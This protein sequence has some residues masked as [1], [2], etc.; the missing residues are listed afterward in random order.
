MSTEYTGVTGAL[1]PN[2]IAERKPV[3]LKRFFGFH[4]RRPYFSNGQEITIWPR[5]NLRL[6]ALGGTFHPG[7]V[8]SVFAR[9]RWFIREVCR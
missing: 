9:I 3:E 8:P 4:K 7:R 5:L 1:P 6:L 2:Y